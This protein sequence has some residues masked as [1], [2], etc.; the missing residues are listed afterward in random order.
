[1]MRSV[2]VSI[3]STIPM[4]QRYYV[5]GH[6]PGPQANL[7]GFAFRIIDREF[8]VHWLSKGPLRWDS[9]IYEIRRPGSGCGRSN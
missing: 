1:M 4:L 3:S 8:F 2:R 9:S 6:E 7:F 5:I